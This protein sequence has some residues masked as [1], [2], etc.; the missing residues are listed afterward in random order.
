MD[1]FAGMSGVSS[2]DRAL[3]DNQPT[4]HNHRDAITH[5]RYLSYDDIMDHRYTGDIRA[6][7][8]EYIA[9][10]HERKEEILV[11]SR[12]I[13]T[14][15]PFHSTPLTREAT[16]RAFYDFKERLYEM[17]FGEQAEAALVQTQCES[18][19]NAVT[20][21]LNNLD[22]VYH[23]FAVNVHDER[24]ALIPSS[25]LSSSSSTHYYPRRSAARVL[26][27][28]H[29][30]QDVCSICGRTY[31]QH[32]IDE[33]GDKITAASI[34]VVSEANPNAMTEEHKYNDVHIRIASNATAT[35]MDMDHLQY[36]SLLPAHDGATHQC[37]VCFDERPVDTFRSTECGHDFYCRQCLT[38]HYRVK[39]NDGDVLKVKCIDPSCDRE[40]RED[41]ILH[42]LVDDDELRAKFEKFKRRKL[43]M[44][45][46]NAR[47]C[48]KADCEGCMIGSRI[49][50]K[51]QCPICSTTVCFNCGKLWHGYFTRCSTAA[52]GANDEMD[53]KFFA[54]EVNKDVKKCPKCKFRIEKNEGL[55]HSANAIH[56]HAYISDMWTF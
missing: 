13:V 23:R 34:A 48:P 50:T 18:V 56:M 8:T 41:E 26:V 11:P 52:H 49:Q 1:G 21:I 54:W 30:A 47:F 37:L 55:C 33:Q 3:S 12:D 40:I 2:L 17:G 42:F 19:E 36:S 25:S 43:L 44:L 24:S 53:Q 14:K 39:I 16:N 22:V 32:L 51:L 9:I 35:D 29:D 45:N 31:E 15:I 28:Q 27:T 5:K 10:G 7:S 4:P 46:E 6:I 20:F 38:E